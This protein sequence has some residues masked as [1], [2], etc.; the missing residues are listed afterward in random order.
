MTLRT[1][2]VRT[3]FP[4]AA[5]AAFALAPAASGQVYYQ[6]RTAAPVLSGRTVVPQSYTPR[7][8]VTSTPGVAV[9]SA[10]APAV[11]YA[12]RMFSTPTVVSGGAVRTS[13]ARYAAPRVV[14]AGGTTYAPIQ[15]RPAGG[16]MMS[17]GDQARAQAEAN[18]MARTGNRG[19]VGGTIGR[20]EGVGWA[21]SGTPTTCTPP[22]GMTLTADALARG[23]GGVYRVR[24]WR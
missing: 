17:G 14:T 1:L 9:R 10:G 2:A 13:G 12:P 23:P 6:T 18:L 16:S 19:H 22:R 20:F 5:V 15:S 4:A 7:R 11:N 24:A 3:L 8:F 21:M